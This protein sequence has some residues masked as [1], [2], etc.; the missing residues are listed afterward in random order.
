VLP[1]ETRNEECP[2][3]DYAEDHIPGADSSSKKT[4]AIKEHFQGQGLGPLIL[5]MTVFATTLSGYAVVGVPEDGF[6]TG[7][8]ACKWPAS[9][10]ALACGSLMIAPRLHQ[11]SMKRS[12]VSPLVLLVACLLLF[13]Q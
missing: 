4:D 11:I 7:F 3:Q 10:L 6:S 12:Y 5:L 8:S 2:P 13:S 9:I 1:D